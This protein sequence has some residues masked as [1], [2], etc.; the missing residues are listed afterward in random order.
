MKIENF[1]SGEYKQQYQ[2]KSFMPVSVNQLWNWNSPQINTLLEQASKALAEL[3]AF[4]LIVPDIDLFIRMHIVKEANQ[5]SRIEG[6]QTHMDEILA[7]KESIDPEKRDD[8]QEVQ[9]YIQALNESL[10]E[11]KQ[12]PLSMRLLKQTHE[13][14][15]SG[16]RGEHKSPG[17]FRTS[18]NW[19]GG[20]N[21]QAAVFIPPHQ[22]DL[23]ELLS[24]LEKFWHNEEIFVPHLI[25]I[26]ITH[27]QFETIHPFLDGNGRIG[28]LLITLYMFSNGLLHKPSLYLSDFLEQHRG[29]YYDAL[30]SVRKSHDL[31]HWIKF[32]LTAVLET[33]T[34]GKETFQNILQ[35][36]QDCEEQIVTLG[37]RTENARKLLL[38]LYQQPIM[39]IKQVSALLELTPRASSSLVTEFIKLGILLEHTGYKRNKEFIF[40]KYL[41][42][43]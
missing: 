8:W 26:A 19:I 43:F 22:S 37:R 13:T 30:T 5:S 41:K 42:L 32:F 10:E 12:L 27:Y 9:N 36:R 31:E 39:S 29:D 14:L 4:S 17:E 15:M 40:D 3:N 1:N 7:K 38:H 2:Y 35:L 34:K 25:R 20:T 24:D 21:L 6:T 16:I 11:L 33:A 18:Q 28:R 23:P